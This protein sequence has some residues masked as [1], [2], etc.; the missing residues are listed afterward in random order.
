LEGKEGG[1]EARRGGGERA[2]GEE[3]GGAGRPAVQITARVV[4]GSRWGTSGAPAQ[5]KLVGSER[6]GGQGGE[7]GTRG[8]GRDSRLAVEVTA[9]GRSKMGI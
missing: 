2:H 6:G 5:H 4:G 8:G 1:H 9:R 7:T 3:G